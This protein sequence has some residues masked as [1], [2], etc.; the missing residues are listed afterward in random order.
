[1]L[2]NIQ[3]VALVKHISSLKQFSNQTTVEGNNNY[4]IAVIATLS[5]W[6]SKSY[7]GFSAS[8]K[9][10]QLFAPVVMGRSYHNTP[11]KTVIIALYWCF[12]YSHLKMTLTC[13][14]LILDSY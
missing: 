7:A 1:M 4:V 12:F 11:L 8:E 9:Q 2:E 5:D 14:N 13:N 10:N 3:G 6:L